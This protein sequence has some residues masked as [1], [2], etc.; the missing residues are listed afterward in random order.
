MEE[1]LLEK[2]LE[3]NKNCKKR[4]GKRNV[5]EKRKTVKSEEEIE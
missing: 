1:Q 5:N 4:K 2:I 3:F